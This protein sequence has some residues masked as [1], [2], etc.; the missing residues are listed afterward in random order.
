M[1]DPMEARRSVGRMAGWQRCKF[2]YSSTKSWFYLG[3]LKFFFVFAKCIQPAK[4]ENRLGF[5]VLFF[6]LWPLEQIQDIGL[7]FLFR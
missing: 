1:L 3:L 5:V 4:L 6:F 2:L 7:Q